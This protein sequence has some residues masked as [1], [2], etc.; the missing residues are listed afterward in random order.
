MTVPMS[1]NVA[2]AHIVWVKENLGLA[3]KSVKRRVLNAIDNDWCSPKFRNWDNRTV[4]IDAVLKEGRETLICIYP[5]IMV[6]SMDSRG[7]F[8]NY[9]LKRFDGGTED[10]LSFSKLDSKNE[11]LKQEV[12]ST[13]LDI[14]NPFFRLQFAIEVRIQQFPRFCCHRALYKRVVF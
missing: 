6:K 5:T 1:I 8:F 13:R 4:E 11:V 7:R 3:S 2:G 14:T 12:L 9:F 10:I